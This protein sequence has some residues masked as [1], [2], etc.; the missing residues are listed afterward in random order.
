VILN[1]RI[2][3]PACG[4]EYPM[5]DAVD[6]EVLRQIVRAGSIFG[7]Q[8][9]EAVELYLKGFQTASNRPLKPD[10]MLLLLEGLAGF[11]K[12]EAVIY[13]RKRYR[14]DHSVLVQA[15]RETGMREKIGLTNHNYLK[16]VAIDL[17]RKTDAIKAREEAQH[18]EKLRE[19]ASHDTGGPAKLKEIIDGLG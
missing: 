14:A 18:E 17:Q 3:C 16:K 9:W 4:A 5:K 15:M 7:R 8:G 19:R 11:W 12:D 1:Q 10:K 13:E 2:T 6:S